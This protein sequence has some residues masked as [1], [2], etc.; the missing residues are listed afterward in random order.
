MLSPHFPLLYTALVDT[1][2]A[3]IHADDQEGFHGLMDKYWEEKKASKAK[4]KGLHQIKAEVKN[5][6][7]MVGGRF[8]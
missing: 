3:L 6:P 1:I 8:M 4:V 7:I 2:S 5:L